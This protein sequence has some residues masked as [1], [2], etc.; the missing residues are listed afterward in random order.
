MSN[1]AAFL[2]ISVLLVVIASFLRKNAAGADKELVHIPVR[3]ET[4]MPP[5]RIPV[6]YRRW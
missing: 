4:I 6:K 2:Q 5:R 1:L 3:M